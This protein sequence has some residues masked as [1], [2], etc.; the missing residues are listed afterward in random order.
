VPDVKKDDVSFIFCTNKKRSKKV[1]LYNLLDSFVMTPKRAQNKGILL[2][3][4]I[5]I[6]TKAQLEQRDSVVGHE[7]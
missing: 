6:T 1:A 4:F 2:Y 3:P 7:V 5:G